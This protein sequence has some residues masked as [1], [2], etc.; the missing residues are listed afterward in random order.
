MVIDSGARAGLGWVDPDSGKPVAAVPKMDFTDQESKL[1]FGFSS[2]APD[3]DN[4][5]SVGS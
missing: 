1:A 2:A 4:D 5:A 3:T